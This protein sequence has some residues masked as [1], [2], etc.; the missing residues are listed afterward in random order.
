MLLL[1]AVHIIP[2]TAKHAAFCPTSSPR[3]HRT[4]TQHTRLRTYLPPMPST[5]R[6]TYQT[7]PIVQTPC[8][9]LVQN[10]FSSPARLGYVS[11]LLRLLSARRQA[12]NALPCRWPPWLW[13]MWEVSVTFIM[14]S[15]MYRAVDKLW[16]KHTSAAA[17]SCCITS[18]RIERGVRRRAATS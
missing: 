3:R 1:L 11:A 6:P 5:G 13:W 14:I 4:A 12:K 18:R 2:Q 15:I 7:K 10:I 8:S 17:R 16:E 9:G